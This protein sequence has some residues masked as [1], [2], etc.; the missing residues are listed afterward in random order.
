MTVTPASRVPLVPLVLL[1]PLVLRAQAG[2]AP[3][4]LCLGVPMKITE[5]LICLGP[6]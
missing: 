6:S 4:S 5:R 2:Q 1:D 3:H